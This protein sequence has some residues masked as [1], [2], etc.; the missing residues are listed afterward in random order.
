MW[1]N[2]LRKAIAVGVA[3]AAV[4]SIAAAAT[5]ALAP[6]TGA[7]APRAT[8]ATYFN[9]ATTR[10]ADPFV[11]YDD[12]SGYYYA[13]S[14]AN[15]DHGYFFAVY[16]SADLVT[17]EKVG[18]GA[19]PEDDRNQWGSEWFWAPEVYHNPA[20]GLYFMFYTARSDAN[21][22]RWFGYSN[23]G[24]PSKIGVAVSRSPAGPFHNIAAHPIDYSPYDPSYHDVNLLMKSNLT[25]P[26]ATLAKG[27]TSRLGTYIPMIDP[28]VLFAPDGRQYLYYSRADRNWTWDSSLGKYVQ[29]SDILAVELTTDW[30]NDPTG[31]TMPA[32]AP[33]YRDSN[34]APG[35]PRGPR[36]DG[37]VR[38]LDYDHGKQAWEN[39][40]VNDYKLSRGTRQDR[41]WEEG[42]TT[43]ERDGVYYLLYSANSWKTPKYGVGYAVA[44]NPLGPWTKFAGNP[45][46]SQSV[47]DGMYSTGH[48]GIAFSPDGTELYY[49]HHGRPTP[50]SVHRW[51]YTE[52][53][54][55]GADGSDEFGFPI[56]S[57]DQST[58]DQP[59]PSGVAPYRIRASVRSLRLRAG[60]TRTVSWRVLSAR[61]AKQALA[62]PLNLVRARSA[63]PS[64]ATIDAH[65]DGGTVSAGDRGR[66]TITLTYQRER[67]RGGY[68]KVYNIVGNERQLVGVTITVTV[69]P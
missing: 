19:L 68:A 21:A 51:L 12:K 4:G 26:P 41:R 43:F 23:F 20:T 65:A 11:L 45:I 13:Y 55:F 54:Q 63:D 50:G 56:L 53:V 15:A 10:G 18:H 37:F 30:W 62:N 59:I 64:V 48:G 47:S 33:A 67:S 3:L 14:T 52:L 5:R 42:S 61:G 25:K 36:R 22:E 24:N 60:G 29:E 2:V 58:S 57:I 46:L 39:A 16:R 27:D 32:I 69:A 40:D 7:A 49:V 35:G 1:E 8:T 17:W 66:T 31:R 44:T 34:D 6:T 38:I 28:D 9:D